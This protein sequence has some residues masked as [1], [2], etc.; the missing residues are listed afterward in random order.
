M[1]A[2][3]TFTLPSLR[4]NFTSTIC[5]LGQHASS[6]VPFK[7]FLS[8]LRLQNFLNSESEDDGDVNDENELRNEQLERIKV[9]DFACSKYSF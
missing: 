9:N 1:V 7:I 4:L 6:L 2:E 5:V 3:E 8:F